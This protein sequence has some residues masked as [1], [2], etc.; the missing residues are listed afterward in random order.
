M[1]SVRVEIPDDVDAILVGAV[2]L[3]PFRPV[4]PHVAVDVDLDHHAG[5]EEAVADALL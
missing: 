3:A 1:T 2:E 5:Y 4:A